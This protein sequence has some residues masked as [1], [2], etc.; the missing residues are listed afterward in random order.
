MV[1]NYLRTLT[2]KIGVGDAGRP[3]PLDCQTRPSW[4]G[5]SSSRK[6]NTSR[7]HTNSPSDGPPT[8]I[9]PQIKQAVIELTLQH[10]NFAICKLHKS[11]LSDSQFLLHARQLPDCV[12][13]RISVNVRTDCYFWQISNERDTRELSSTRSEE[14]RHYFETCS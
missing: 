10:P 4:P 14:P 2:I 9:T 11:F 8:K 5:S 13:W 6:S 7:P 12:I 1:L 3:L